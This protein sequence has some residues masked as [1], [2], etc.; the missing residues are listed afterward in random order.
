M[1]CIPPA[2]AGTLPKEASPAGHLF[3]QPGQPGVRPP[4][5]GLIHGMLEYTTMIWFSDANWDSPPGTGY[6]RV[7]VITISAILTAMMTLRTP[8]RGVGEQ[9]QDHPSGSL[10]LA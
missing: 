5:F 3:Q 8:R 1:G 10:T 4:A 7:A 9:H 2:N 6:L